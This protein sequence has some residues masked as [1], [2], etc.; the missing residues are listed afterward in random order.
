MSVCASVPLMYCIQ[1]DKDIVGLFPR[2]S[3]HYHSRFSSPSPIPQGTR[4]DV[5]Y[6]T[7]W[8]ICDFPLKSPFVSETVRD[9]PMFAVER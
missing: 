4:G 7:V 9:T 8:K 1:T 6:T 5:K 3:S 2:P